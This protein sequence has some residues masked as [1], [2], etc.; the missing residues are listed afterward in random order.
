[1]QTFDTAEV[2]YYLTGHGE[3]HLPKSVGT[4]VLQKPV[5]VL[6]MAL[7]RNLSIQLALMDIG[8]AKPY[9]TSHVK[10]KKEKKELSLN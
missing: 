6:V 7:R 4:F 5:Q 10:R 3:K 2:E 1:M 8:L 9:K